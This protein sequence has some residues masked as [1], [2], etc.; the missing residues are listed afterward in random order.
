[1]GPWMYY[2]PLWVG[3]LLV[4]AMN[5][6]LREKVPGLSPAMQW[7]VV[8]A[9]AISVGL[10]FQILMIGA[11]G[12]F[13]Q[14]IPV[15]WGRSIRGGSAMAIGWLVILTSVLGWISGF[16]SNEAV[17]TA[18]LILGGLALAALVAAALLYIWNLPAAMPDFREERRR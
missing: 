5:D 6:A 17:L 14:V 13:A 10:Q 16:L 18:G 15:P 12:A 2:S 4:M 8:A 7:T 3:A 9:V 1:M 11:Q